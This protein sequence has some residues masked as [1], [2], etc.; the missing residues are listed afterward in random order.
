MTHT[1]KPAPSQ[2]IML[3]NELVLIEQKVPG[4][5]PRLIKAIEAGAIQGNVFVGV[6][7]DCGCVYGHVAQLDEGRAEQL[8]KA[9]YDQLYERYHYECF[10]TPLEELV[11]CVKEGETHETNEELAT[12]HATLQTYITASHT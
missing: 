9:V 4:F 5:A 11:S 1:T 6:T 7:T 12:L 10:V 2:D 3:R 8:E